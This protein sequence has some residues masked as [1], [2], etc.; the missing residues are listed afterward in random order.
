MSRP[1][2]V[3]KAREWLG[4]PFLHQGRTRNGVDCIGLA[5]KVAH[6]LDL[7]DFDDTRYGRRPSGKRMKRLLR[8]HC[9]PLPF[10]QVEAGD[11]L[12]FATD[13]DPLHVALITRVDPH[14]VIHA[15]REFGEVVEQRL[16]AVMLRKLRGC[17]RLPESPQWVN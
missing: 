17:Y 11:L 12:H 2:V 4:V 14:Y 6:Q 1:E 15:A 8:A 16:D 3:S 10:S 13:T 7:T 5:I 9:L